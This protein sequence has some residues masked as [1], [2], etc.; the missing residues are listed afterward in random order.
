L[1]IILLCDVATGAIALIPSI[2]LFLLVKNY[3][4]GPRDPTMNDDPVST[5]VISAIWFIGALFPSLIAN[6][7][8][9]HR[10]RLPSWLLA[11]I[12]ISILIVAISVYI[13]VHS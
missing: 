4:I 1:A 2:I 3:L 8:L 12:A 10:T 9:G 11:V 5:A 13:L 6:M 7:S